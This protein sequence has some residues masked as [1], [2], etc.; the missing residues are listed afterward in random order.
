M[1]I[2]AVI[3]AKGNSERVANKNMFRIKNESL[4]HMACAKLL[5]TK[6][7]NKVYL[8]TDCD[9]IIYDVNDLRKEGL[10]IIKRPIEL[11][12]NDISANDLLI[13]A[14]HSMANCDLI[15]QTFA[16]SPLITANT[17]DNCISKFLDQ[18]NK[19][20]YDSFFTVIDM[21]EYFWKKD[22]DSFKPSNFDIKTL[23]NSF[24]LL[25]IYMETHG[26][27]GIFSKALI[28]YKTRVGEKP[29]LI[30]IPKSEA[31]DINEYEDLTILEKLL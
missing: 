18:T 7:I 6:T 29:Y 17:I 25:P 27:Y 14:L 15:I 30:Q 31:H 21:Y 5:R 22:G 24:E 2:N 12:N 19:N 3:P 20:D 8:D 13:Y 23:P 26:L 9:E 28:K 10:E 1:I 4:V 16:T 11:A